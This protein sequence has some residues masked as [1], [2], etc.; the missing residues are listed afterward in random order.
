LLPDELGFLQ[1]LR[2]AKVEPNE[3][4]FNSNKVANVQI[5]LEQLVSKNYYLHV[6][7]MD[8]YRSYLQAYA[9]H[10]LKDIYNVNALNL[11]HVCK[12]FGFSVPPKVNLSEFPLVPWEWMDV[13][14]KFM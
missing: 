13:F 2:A 5:K 9:S 10:S 4:D 7:A 3:Y 11:L 14:C 12:S 6:A 1:Y 8:A